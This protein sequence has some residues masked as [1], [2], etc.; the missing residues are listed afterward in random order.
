MFL[1]ML[2]LPIFTIYNIIKIVIYFLTFKLLVSKII[3]N[4]LKVNF[5]Q[6]IFFLQFVKKYL[7]H[8]WCTREAGITTTMKQENTIPN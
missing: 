7:Q 8:Y 4:Q 5:E 3:H 1:I 6:N 2:A